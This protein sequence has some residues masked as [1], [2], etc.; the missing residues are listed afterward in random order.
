[1]SDTQKIIV[2]VKWH[3]GSKVV[4]QAIPVRNLTHQC[5]ESKQ[6]PQ[7]YSSILCDSVI[8]FRVDYKQ[9]VSYCKYKSIPGREV[10]HKNLFA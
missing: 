8:Y 10:A 3:G 7:N 5:R 4:W 6:L 9:S 1:M 2:T